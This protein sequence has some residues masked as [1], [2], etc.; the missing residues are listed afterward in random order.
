M[1]NVI[2]DPR[3]EAGGLEEVRGLKVGIDVKA[4]RVLKGQGK[5]GLGG[6]RLQ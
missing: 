1:P 5:T 2:V 4:L 6:V 3:G